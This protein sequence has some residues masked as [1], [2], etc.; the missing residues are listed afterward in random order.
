MK[1][2]IIGLLGGALLAFPLNANAQIS[3]DRPGA[4]AELLDVKV[5]VDNFVRAATNIEF[6]KYVSLAGG[7]NRFYHFRAPTPIDNQPTIRMN[8]D[9]LYSAAV[10]DISEGATITL[11]D[12]GKRYM[13]AMVINQDHYI[14][15]VFVGGGTYTLDME[16]FDTPYAIVFMRV[17]VDAA[18]PE[19]VAAVNAL[20]DQMA[21]KAASSKPFIVPDYDD[22]SFKGMVSAILGLAQYT[23]DSFRMF[24]AKTDVDPIRHYIGTAGGYGG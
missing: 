4:H 16:K 22:D 13:S 8:R 14:N 6:G 3:A 18:D 20:Q 11:P 5:T 19:D 12:V 1:K 23:P 2:I 24:G 15:D 21:V 17:L 9:T 10:V 7:I